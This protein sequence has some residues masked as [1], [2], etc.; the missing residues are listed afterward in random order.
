MTDKQNAKKIDQYKKNVIDFLN[1]HRYK[2]DMIEKPTHQSWGN[3]IQGRFYIDNTEIK[4]FME[5]YSDAIENNVTDL[6]I[7]EVQKEFSPIIVDVDLKI[8]IEDYDNK[9]LYDNKLIFDIIKKFLLIIDTYLEYDRTNFK[10]CLFEKEN[11]TKLDEICKDGFHIMFPDICAN[12]NMRHLIRHKVVKLCNESETFEIFLEDAEKIIDKAVVSSNGWFLYGSKKPGGQLYK[13]TKVYNYNL[14]EVNLEGNVIKYLS[15]HYKKKRYSKSAMTKLKNDYIDTDINA[16]INK[17]GINTN[18]KP[19]EIKFEQSASK[20]DLIRRACT[21]INILN[22]DRAANYEEWRNVGLALHNTDESLLPTWIDFSSKCKEKFNEGACHKFWKQFKTPLSGNLLTIRSLAYWAK[23]DN[24]KE[25]ELFINNEFKKNREDSID[26]S[27]YK[28]AKSFYAK[29]SDRFACSSTKSNLWWEFKNHRWNRIED[30]YTIKILLSEEFQ[31]DYR[32]DIIEMTIRATKITGFEKEQ[33]Q[34]KISAVNK[35]IERLMNIDFKKKVIEEAK[36][37]FLEP[38]FDDKLDSNIN[39]IGFENGVYDLEQKIFRDGHPDD[40]ISLSTK[41]NYIK[42]SEKMPY[43]KHI[44]TFFTQVLPNEKVRKYFLQALSTCLSG[45]TKEEKLYILTGSGSNGK[46]LSMDL[47]YASLGDYYMSCPITI[48]TRKRGQSNETAP[49][50]VRMRGKRCGVFQET[51]DGEKLNVGVMKEFTG[52]DKVL[53]RDLFKGA[54]EM[55]EFKPQMKYFLTCNQLPTVPSNDDGTWRRLR[56]IEFGS[57]FT[58]NPTKPNEFKINTSLKQDIQKW[59]T[60]FLSYLI[61]IY[62]TEYKGTNYLK[63]PDEVM[64]STN[65]YKMENDFYTEYYMDRINFTNEPKNRIT[66]EA[67]YGDFKSWY[68]TNYEGK[69]MPKKPEFEKSINKIIGEPGK[70]YYQ[71]I[72]FNINTESDNDSN[73]HSILDT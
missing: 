28:I 41:N 17:L 46:S 27:T 55:I 56:V 10:I 49:E 2:D 1:N 37:L 9:R 33:V 14:N 7:L 30:A 11:L 19:Q 5:I 4:D 71:K 3:I 20:E 66:R 50:K 64:A 15:L 12:P 48:I 57:K 44:I 39:L 43:Y 47:M 54:N 24:P 26:G 25:Y 16:E 31:N 58:D 53:V 34:A 68:K 40:F 38:K 42:F 29:Y 51:D 18:L 21:Y 72:I 35:I 36:S 59:T 67:L 60:T 32:N 6:S 61:Y 62:E 65:Q 52:G 13:L 8:P 23:Q 22:E 69:P 45:E 63:E 73:P 70:I